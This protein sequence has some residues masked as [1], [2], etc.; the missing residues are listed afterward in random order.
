MSSKKTQ[1]KTATTSLTNT[2][3]NVLI[4][5]PCVDGKVDAW[6]VNSLADTIRVAMANNVY[7]KPIFLVN[8]DS[9]PMARNELFKIAYE[10]NFNQLIFINADIGWDPLALMEIIYADKAVIGLPYPTRNEAYENYSVEIENPGKLTQDE[11]TGY[12]K[13]FQ[14][15]AGFL[16]MDRVVIEALWNSNTFLE[17]KGK[18]LKCICEYQNANLV[19]NSDEVALCNKI[20]NLGFDIWTQ[21]KF[22]CIRTGTKVYSGSYQNNIDALKQQA[23]IFNSNSLSGENVGNYTADL[24]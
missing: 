13:V 2:P 14:H 17:Y 4:G 22:T 5:T 16:K 12:I 21:P 6:Y 19:F 3:K 9:L 15:G 8:E 24:F 10:N 11:K 20:K 7:I 1:T 23:S 18:Q